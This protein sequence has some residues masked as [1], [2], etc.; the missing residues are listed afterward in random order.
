MIEKVKTRE[1]F[2][3]GIAY[4]SESIDDAMAMLRVVRPAEA[5]GVTI[6]RKTAQN[7]EL[8]DSLIRQTE[9]VVT[10]RGF[11]QDYEAYEKVIAYAHSNRKPVVLDLD[12]LLLE[13]PENH[14]DR[15]NGQFSDTLLP[16]FQ[17]VLDADLVTVATEP[18]RE[19]MLPY[20]YNVRVIPNYFDDSLWQFRP[21]N[22]RT[23]ADAPVTIG[24][25]GG[26][27]H[28]PDLKMILPALLELM[29][30]YPGR[31]RFKFWGIQPPSELLPFSNV[32]WA[33]PPTYRYADFAEYFQTQTA[34]IVIAPLCD[35]LFNA[36]KSAIKFFEYSAI[37]VPGVYSRIAPYSNMIED[38]WDGLLAG[39]N[40]EWV[41]AIS[42]LIESP[43]T[44]KDLVERA[45][46]KIRSHWLLSANAARQFE[47]YD[48][49]IAGHRNENKVLPG[50]Y[51]LIHKIT[52]QN[53]E[54]KK[55]RDFII[56][57]MKNQVDGLYDQLPVEQK[58]VNGEIKQGQD[59][60]MP[61][62]RLAARLN[63]LFFVVRD[64]LNHNLILEKQV[65]AIETEQN[66]LITELH[67]QEVERNRLITELHEQV[68]E[69]DR[70]TRELNRT[71]ILA[72]ELENEVIQCTSSRSWRWTRPFRQIFKKMRRRGE[73]NEAHIT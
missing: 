8:D 68:A 60:S 15:L 34:D 63:S 20:N 55:Q 29:T 17:A 65:T 27:S 57:E 11:S 49:L 35:N 12:D 4:F 71:S 73:V 36:C 38:G 25:M 64:L 3:R 47:I 21:Y 42:R 30:R 33:P 26:H 13:L 14:P 70:L 61:I 31:I 18:L 58:N 43:K 45:R 40:D 16:M 51:N 24:Y 32:N 52:I 72:A 48:E 6:R 50:F 56:Q 22:G 53:Y 9:V 66:K 41:D 1:W 39:A 10:Q 5:A 67:K 44:G 28:E 59:N 2:S 54:T 62:K 23:K 69:R 37:G 7:G 46:Q 19:Y